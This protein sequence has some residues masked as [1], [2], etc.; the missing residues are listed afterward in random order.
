ML[1][2]RKVYLIIIVI[3]L[4]IGCSSPVPPPPPPVG[5]DDNGRT[6]ETI[7]AT[8]KTHTTLKSNII[9]ILDKP[10]T[11]ENGATLTIEPGT[12]IKC[13]TNNSTKTKGALIIK[14]G[15]KINASGT[16]DKPII[17]TSNKP[18]G[19]RSRGDWA[20]IVILGNAP[21]NLQTNDYLTTARIPFGGSNPSDNSGTLKYVRI[22]FAGGIEGQTLMN[23]IN[24]N[25]LTLAG[26]GSGTQ[27]SYVQISDCEDDA[28]E[29]IGGTVNCKY[30]FSFRNRLT[31]FKTSFGYSGI[32]QYAY[33]HKDNASPTSAANC[34]FSENDF[35]GS[36]NTPITTPTFVNCTFVGY[37]T[38]VNF[39]NAV[40]L[41]NNTRLALLN[42]VIIGH[43]HSIFLDGTETTSNAG[44]GM[45]EVQGCIISN[46]QKDSLVTN[47][48]FNIGNWFQKPEYF[49]QSIKDLGNL[50]IENIYTSH[51]NPIPNTNSPLRTG[52]SFQSFRL[53]NSLIEQAN[54]RGAFD[55]VDWTLGWTSF[56]SNNLDY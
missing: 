7:Q 1:N 32:V 15:A 12:I 19:Q 11:V 10:V 9:Y 16:V 55:T 40:H 53:A 29:F 44:A 42:S 14:P 23:P 25:A 48:S 3:L 50:G 37:N 18:K 38:Q 41:R 39:S 24:W 13:G 51:P 33:A 2:H 31:D 46:W 34:L 17:F 6:T 43:N 45:L 47:V 20:G 28:F 26:V 56:N 5:T 49:N 35:G 8:I 52:A 22:E 54:F 4:K 30:L 27:I 21:V 36:Y